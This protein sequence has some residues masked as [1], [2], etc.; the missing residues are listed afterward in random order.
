[1]KEKSRLGPWTL[2]IDEFQPLSV[3][4]TSVAPHSKSIE[5]ALLLQIGATSAHF[6]PPPIQLGAWKSKKKLSQN[7]KYLG[8]ISSQMKNKP[9]GS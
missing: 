7:K 6:F 4:I 5:I 8:F 1:M 9:P 3:I 2:F